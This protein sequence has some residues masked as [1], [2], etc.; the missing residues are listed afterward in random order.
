MSDVTDY[1]ADV[2]H[3]AMFAVAIIPKEDITAYMA[4]VFP[5]AD[6]ILD[7]RNACAMIAV[8]RGADLGEPALG[9][10]I[11]K[12]ILKTRQGFAVS[13]KPAFT[14]GHCENKSQPGGCQL[15]NLQCGYPDCDRRPNV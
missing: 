12:A 15:H 8:R 10:D 11:A 1:P 5:V 7:E 13:E 3:V 9:G 2:M 14:T 6:A 4:R